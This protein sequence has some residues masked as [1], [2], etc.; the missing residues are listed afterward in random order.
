MVAGKKK[1]VEKKAPD[2][3]IKRSLREDAEEHLARFPEKPGDLNGQAKD[4][5]I[6]ELRVHQIELETQ[7]EELRRTQQVLEESWDKYVDLYDFAPNGYLT[8]TESGLIDDANLTAATMLGVERQNLKTDRF[9]K[10]VVPEDSDAWIR[11]FMDVKNT[12]DK[13]TTTL[14]LV[15]SNGS[16]FPARLESIRIGSKKEKISFVRVAVSDITDIRMVEDA[17]RVSNKKLSLLSSINRHDLKNHLLTLNAYLE[18]SKE[19]FGDAAKMSDIVTKE[20]EIIKTVSRWVAFTKEYEQ[21]G[22]RTPAWQNCRILVDTAGKQVSHV[23]VTIEDN[24]P[25]DLEVLA[26]PLIVKAFYNL[27]ENAVRHGGKITTMRFSA[28]AGEGD[29]IVVCEDDGDGIVAK[30]KE[31]IFERGFGKNTGLGLFLIRE[32]LLITGIRIQETGKVG[33]GARFEIFVPKGVYRCTGQNL[34]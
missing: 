15:R 27:I 34:Y 32:I 17:L 29:Y 4:Q 2:T 16:A 1:P 10:F 30:D 8:L 5:I 12:S 14:N 11:Y 24:L 3:G 28:A 20:E 22:A 13:L 23:G 7:A 9:R 25:A 19:Y 33:E 21:V 26:D 18:I 31:I 6:H